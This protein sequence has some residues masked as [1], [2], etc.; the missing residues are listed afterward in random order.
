MGL[1]NRRPEAG[2]RK[3]EAGSILKPENPEPKLGVHDF[4]AGIILLCRAIRGRVGDR[5]N[6]TYGE[7]IIVTRGPRFDGYVPSAAQRDRREKM[8]AATAYAQAVYADP[9]ARAVYVVT[10]KQ[11]GRQPFRL[12]VS[13]FLHARPRVVLAAATH[14][15][16]DDAA[17]PSRNRDSTKPDGHKRLKRRRNSGL[18][19][20]PS[21]PFAA[22]I[23]SG[24]LV[25]A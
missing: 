18:V 3:E 13:D 1:R 4:L 12:A 19:F 7:K 14:E 10:A 15:N 8:R 17:R 22:I 25:A 11:L 23:G 6:K 2:N 5:V 24:S 9:A 16:Q 20:A 21:E